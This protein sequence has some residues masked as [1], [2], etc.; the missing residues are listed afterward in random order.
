MVGVL[1]PLAS[2]PFFSVDAY[3][4]L[5]SADADASP[6]LL[7]FNPVPTGQGLP[8]LHSLCPVFGPYPIK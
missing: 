4:L 7:F 5:Y 1:L 2:F 6:F 8:F 3:I